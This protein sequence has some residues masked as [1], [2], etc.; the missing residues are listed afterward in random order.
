MLTIIFVACLIVISAAM[1]LIQIEIVKYSL[2]LWHIRFVMF[3]LFFRLQSRD[4]T[5]SFV[6]LVATVYGSGGLLLLSFICEIGQVR[7]D[8][9]YSIT[10][11]FQLNF[12]EFEPDQRFSNLTDGINDV[13]IQ[14]VWY[15]FPS[16]S[17]RVLPIVM[18]S[19]QEPLVVKCFGNVSCAR[20]QFKKVSLSS[21]IYSYS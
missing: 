1:L 14:M 15:L 6:L 2:S 8:R 18:Q 16:E 5:D 9:C 19:A 21:I 10:K 7:I 3:A 11:Y 13:I 12:M 17:R 4:K 20:K